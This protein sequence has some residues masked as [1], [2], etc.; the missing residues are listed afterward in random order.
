MYVPRIEDKNINGISEFRHILTDKWDIIVQQRSKVGKCSK[1]MSHLHYESSE[2]GR[3]LRGNDALAQRWT[4]DANV[5][6]PLEC[7]LVKTQCFEKP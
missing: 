6:D 1:K 5:P 2:M 3:S 7:S 4:T